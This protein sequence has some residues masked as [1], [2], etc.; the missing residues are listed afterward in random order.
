MGAIFTMKGLVGAALFGNF[1]LLLR[2]SY[3]RTYSQINYKVLEVFVR[4]IIRKEGRKI[5]C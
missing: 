4:E 1:I 5:R 3:S 2:K